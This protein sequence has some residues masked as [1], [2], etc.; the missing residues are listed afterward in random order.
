LLTAALDILEG[1]YE[2]AASL[3]QQTPPPR[4]KEYKKNERMHHRQIRP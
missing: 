2:K 1:V 3:V 4:F